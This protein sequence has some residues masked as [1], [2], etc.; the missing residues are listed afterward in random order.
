MSIL[1]GFLLSRNWRDTSAGLEFELWAATEHGPARILITG[2]ESVFFIDRAL[3]A[4]PSDARRAELALTSLSGAP[5]D[6]L[7]FRD[8]RRMR[9]ASETLRRAGTSTYESDVK[10]LDRFLMERFVRGG[11]TIDG[12]AR[13]RGAYVEFR[14]PG[15][16]PSSARPKLSLASMDIETSD[17]DGEL[18]SIAVTMSGNAAVFMRGEGEDAD[19]ITYHADERA[20]LDAFFDW[21]READPD[22]LIGWNLIDFDLDFLQ[23]CCERLRIPFRLGRANARAAVLAPQTAR[24]TS[25]ARV[26]GRAVLDGTA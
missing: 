3:D 18:Y 16:G 8:H 19:G 11:I 2:Q 22:V 24:Q 6:G 23:R 21:M 7:Y 17:F 26:P 10:P 20:L 13:D 9:Q 25:V 14:D 1:E 5:V 4:A 15:I 12:E